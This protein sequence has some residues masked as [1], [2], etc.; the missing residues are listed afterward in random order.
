M[1]RKISFR[2]I[3]SLIGRSSGLD[4]KEVTKQRSK[5]GTNEIVERVGSPWLELIVDTLKDPM[6]WFLVSISAVFYFIGEFSESL[7]LILATLPLIFMDA[8]LHFR[9]QASTAGLRSQLSSKVTLLREGKVVIVDS[10]DIVPGDLVVLSSKN[11]FLPADGYWEE[12]D[13]LQVDESVLT[14][15]AFPV[16]KSSIEFDPFVTSGEAFVETSVLGFAG[17]RVLTGKGILRVLSTGK[18]TSY[19]EIVQSVVKISHERT[20]LQSAILEL[21]RL[22]VY[23]SVVLC[24]AI[25]AIRFYQGH[26]WLDALL[27]AAV[28]AVAALPEEF[29]VVFSFFLGVGVYRLAKHHALVRRAVSVENIGRVTQICTDKTGTITIGKL[30]LAHFV[31]SDNFSQTQILLMALAASN[32][33][34]SDPV[35]IALISEAKLRG[36]NIPKRLN[37]IPFTEDR[38]RESGFFLYDNDLICAIKGSPEV[39]LSKS[40]LSQNEKLKWI[41]EVENLAKGG[42]KVLAVGATLVS[43]AGV[44]S[45]LEPEGGITL[46][47]IL[48]FEDPARPEVKE[49]INYCKDNAIKVLMITGDHPDTAGAIAKDVGLIDSKPIIVSAELEPEKLEDK[50]ILKNPNFFKSVDIVARCNPIQKLRIVESLKRVGEL[51]VVTGDG[52]NDVPA[53]KAADIGVAMGLRGTRSAREVSSII[54]TDDNFSTIVNAIREGKQLFENLRMSF[55]YLLLIHMPFVLTAAIIPLLGY[56]LLYLPI[57]VVWLELIIHPIALFAFQQD[58]KQ[59]P[60]RQELTTRKSFFNR[61]DLVIILGIGLGLTIILVIFYISAV[62]EGENVAH[63]RAKVMALLSL[64]SAGIV[65]ALTGGRTITAK[66]IIV[67]TTIMTI[68]LI[69]SSLMDKVLHLTPLH[70]VDWAKV[71][72]IIFGFVLILLKKNFQ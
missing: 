49:A 51:V 64:W 35:D 70:L 8:F 24:L 60:R 33:E 27:S 23:A 11:L 20:P 57:H 6:V 19:G 45:C 17:T 42:H 25:A 48:A 66:L 40:D 55:K 5:F 44:E 43:Q 34:G 72:A 12:V 67:M 38:K 9:T 37:V 31:T 14:G 16:K 68:V 10:L 69:H 29:P 13:S 56:P 26:G 65:V 71:C 4:E 53:L 58:A 46:Y 62:A 32:A 3:V 2:N 63:G 39:V 1:Q 36:I 59:G 7:I 41:K 18:S 61:R 30:E 50:W 22:L 15:E 54:L 28:L 52:V 47:G 21:T